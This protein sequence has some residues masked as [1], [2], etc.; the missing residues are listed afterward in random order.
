[1]ARIETGRVFPLGYFIGSLPRSG[2]LVPGKVEGMVAPHSQS[3][4]PPESAFAAISLS[5]VKMQCG[6]REIPEGR[7]SVSQRVRY[8]VFY[9]LMPLGGAFS[10]QKKKNDC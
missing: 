10:S 8:L 5:G 2:S 4:T 6:V 1:M 3:L 7:A 9:R